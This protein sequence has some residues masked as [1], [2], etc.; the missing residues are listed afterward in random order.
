MSWNKLPLYKID[1]KISMEN[2]FVKSIFHF[3]DV[4]EELSEHMSDNCYIELYE[5]LKFMKDQKWFIKIS[6]P[7]LYKKRYEYTSRNKVYYATED[8]T[9]CKF[10]AHHYVDYTAHCRTFKHLKNRTNMMEN[11]R[12]VNG[13]HQTIKGYKTGVLTIPTNV[14]KKIFHQIQLSEYITQ[15]IKA[16]K[17]SI[18]IQ[19]YARRW[20]VN[21][22]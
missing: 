9:Y 12:Q 21:N 10:C 3:G 5:H 15:K 13:H 16:Q 20:L 8:L 2:N 6:D 1:K 4:I 11:M 17:S 19:K 14:D 22:N 7:V 18:K